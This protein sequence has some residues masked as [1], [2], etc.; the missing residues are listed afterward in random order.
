MQVSSLKQEDLCSN[1]ELSCLIQRLLY[2]ESSVEVEWCFFRSRLRVG[3]NPNDTLGNHRVTQ[4]FLWNKQQGHGTKTNTFLDMS[5]TVMLNSFIQGCPILLLEAFMQSFSLT[6]RNHIWT[7][8]SGFSG[9]LESYCVLLLSSAGR[10]PSRS[11]FGIGMH[12]Y[13]NFVRYR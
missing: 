11:R 12:Q 2:W 8:Y 13:K 10:L 5:C 1:P 7:S 3:T 9:L 4:V 6:L